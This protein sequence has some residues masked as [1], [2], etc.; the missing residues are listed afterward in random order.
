MA[1]S[2]RQFFL[3]ANLSRVED[4]CGSIWNLKKSSC[5][6]LLVVQWLSLC[7]SNAGATGSDPGQGA[8]IPHAL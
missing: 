6:T 3:L 7:A 1:G 4:F 2:S 5:G 8:K